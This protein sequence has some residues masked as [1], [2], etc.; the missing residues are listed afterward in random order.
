[1]CIL[2]QNL[3]VTVV[4]VGNPQCVVFVRDFGLDWRGLG[5]KIEYHPDFPNRTNVSFVRNSSRNSIEVRFWERG[6]GETMSS[7]TGSTG[8]AYAAILR[9][10]VE[11]PVRVST[12][13]GD[14]EFRSVNDTGYLTGPAELV[15]SGEFYVRR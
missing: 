15:G 9:D 11:S 2:N 14:L 1:L 6:A 5:A 3:D 4:N 8:A 7:G 12:P 10:L 13:A